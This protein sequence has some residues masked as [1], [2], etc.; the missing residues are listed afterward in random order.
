MSSFIRIAP[1]FVVNDLELALSFYS[2]LGFE[3]ERHDESLG[4]AKADGF[5]FHIHY[6]AEAKPSNHVWWIEVKEI[7]ELYDKCQADKARVCSEI[8]SQPWGFREF[9]IRD[10]FN[11]LLIFAESKS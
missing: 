3:V 6:D 8:Q 4:F 11:N 7:D 1:R 9:H 10:P 2:S 5:D